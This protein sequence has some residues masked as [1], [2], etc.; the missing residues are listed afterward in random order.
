MLQLVGTQGIATVLGV[1]WIENTHLRSILPIFHVFTRIRN[2]ALRKF[3][4]KACFC[5]IV[6]CVRTQFDLALEPNSIF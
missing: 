3:Y 6:L 1:V 4:L 5:D 2:E